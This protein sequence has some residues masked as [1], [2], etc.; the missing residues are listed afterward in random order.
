MLPS[1][2]HKV[3]RYILFPF[4]RPSVRLFLISWYLLF[5]DLGNAVVASCQGEVVGLVTVSSTVNLRVLQDSFALATLV[6]MEHHSQSEHGEIDIYCM[7]PIF[8]H[9]L[10][11]F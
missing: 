7:N 4:P 3:G 10:V 6:T 5:A 9:R 1:S 2:L 11:G 8:A